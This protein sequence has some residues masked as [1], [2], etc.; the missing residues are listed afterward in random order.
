M[1]V[2]TARGSSHEVARIVVASAPAAQSTGLV[3]NAARGTP[4]V[5]PPVKQNSSGSASEPWQSWPRSGSWM[6]SAGTPQS[7]TEE[8][9][10]AT[11][12]LTFGIFTVRP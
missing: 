12:W 10:R 4:A 7:V 9:V 1:R 11:I 2:E 6:L 3:R 5:S 8:P